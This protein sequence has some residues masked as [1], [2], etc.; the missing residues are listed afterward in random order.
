MVKVLDD[1]SL[2]SNGGVSL[3]KQE[4]TKGVEEATGAVFG[5]KDCSDGGAAA[6]QQSAN[7]PKLPNNPQLRRKKL[8]LA[9]KM[10][11]LPKHLRTQLRTQLLR[12][13]LRKRLR[14][15]S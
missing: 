4:G 10:A 3:A 15:Q 13:R 2:R 14:S 1:P 12:K 7:E 9:N 8:Q 5:V 6:E 11:Q